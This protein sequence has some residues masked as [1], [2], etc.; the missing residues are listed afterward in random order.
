MALAVEAALQQEAPLNPFYYYIAVFCATVWFYTLAYIT[1]S[2][3][4]KNINER[5]AWYNKHRLFIRRSQ[6]MMLFLLLLIGGFL[7]VKYG[8]KLT[9]ITLVQWVLISLFPVVGAL[10]YGITN[11]FNLRRIGW[12]KPF[13][14]GFTWAGIANV[15]PLVYHDIVQDAATQI[16]FVNVV[17]FVKN[18]MFVTVLCIMFDIK[19]YADDY[20]KELKTFVVN[21][22]L[23][24]TIF[25]ILIPLSVTGLGCFLT[26]AFMEHYSVV[27]ILLNTI[28]FISMIA[29]AYSMHQRK[30]I[31]YYLVLIDGLM[32][33]KAIC[34]SVAMLFF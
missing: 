12:L 1:D 9:A 27:K 32:L 11:T 14:I 15:Y 8:S 10:Y 6:N 17:L 31:L 19:D 22:G 34:G 33:L 2:P 3:V 16:Q 20:N 29:V 7:V 18:F 26:Y 24:K 4:T 25:Y 28:P 5:S 13:L 23:R 30:P 21:N